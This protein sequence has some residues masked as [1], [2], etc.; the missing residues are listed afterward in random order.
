VA[1]AAVI[2]RTLKLLLDEMHA[3]AI[4]EALAVDGWDVVAV[5]SNPSLRGLPDE[6]LLIYATAEEQT[7][8]T[9]NVV[10]FATIASQWAVIG[11]RHAGLIFT[12]PKR[13]NRA[14][15]AYPGNVLAALRGVLDSPPSLGESGTWWL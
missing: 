4:A 13:F 10:D 3:P 14:Q 2:A 11:R 12:N 1:A 9:E 8:V 5:A 15:I 6:E 7:I